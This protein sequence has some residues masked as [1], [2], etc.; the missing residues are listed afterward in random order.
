MAR[1]TSTKILLQTNKYTYI[2]ILNSRNQAP[3]RQAAMLFLL[4]NFMHQLLTRMEGVYYCGRVEVVY[5]HTNTIP[6]L[7]RN[8]YCANKTEGFG[9][10]KD[11]LPS[12]RQHKKVFESAKVWPLNSRKC[13]ARSPPPLLDLLSLSSFPDP[14]I[15]TFPSKFQNGRD[16]SQELTKVFKSG[17][18]FDKQDHEGG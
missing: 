10:W 12:L 17:A 7:Y 18:K 6:G 16:N 15:P 3:G 4:R 11:S 9:N 14:L 8:F 1:K 2:Y 5:D 13:S